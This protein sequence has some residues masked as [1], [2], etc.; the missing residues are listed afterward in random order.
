MAHERSGLVVKEWNG[1]G[2][3]MLF[4]DTPSG[5]NVGKYY[6]DTRKIYVENPDERRLVHLALQEWQ[7][8]TADTARGPGPRPRAADGGA[9]VDNRPGEALAAVARRQQPRNRAVRLAA[10]VL[11]VRTA[12]TAYRIGVKGERRVGRRLARLERSGWT[13]LHGLQLPGGG[14]VDH[15]LIGPAGVY[16]V[17]TKFHKR[18]LVQVSRRRVS[19]R[20]QTV[21]YV[22]AAHREADRVRTEVFKRLHRPVN[23]SPVLVIHGGRVR[24][25]IF[26]RPDGVPVLPSRWARTWFRLG[27]G[28]AVLSTE[29]IDELDQVL[30]PM[31]QHVVASS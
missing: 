27:G 28:R 3:R 17:N 21:N 15:V 9:R 7:A 8:G 14:D 26:H 22:A 25:W 2:K 5:R 23:I 31:A 1:H 16:T 11:R 12:D 4:V 6:R 13:V 20:G 29:D 10:R 18:A 19:V 30:R 24:G